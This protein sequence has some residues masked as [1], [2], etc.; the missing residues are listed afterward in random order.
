MLF[1]R[2]MLLV[3]SD[4]RFAQLVQTHIHKSFLLTTPA[5]RFEDLA[6][7]V[8]RD[9]DG[10]LL[11]LASDAQDAER[12]DAS[13]R[14]LR[15]QQLPP[16]LAVLSA[17]Q[18]SASRRLDALAPF[19]DG[20]FVWPGHLR[21]FNSWIRRAVVPGAPFP[22]TLTE[23]LAQR[24]RG[25]LLP[26]TPSLA[27]LADQLEIAATHDVTVLIE[28]ETGTGKSYLAKLIHDFS[29]RAAH[30]FLV[31]AG[32]AH[33]GHLLA[34]EF[35]GH[36]KG[37]FSGADAGKVGK[38]EAAGAGTLLIDEID[39]LTLDQQANLLRVIE[40]G[41]FEPVGSNETQRSD[42]RIIVAT[43]WNLSE[44]VALGTFRN[45]LYYRLN[46]LPFRIP[47]LRDRLQDVSPL[48]RGMVARYNTRFAK[49]IG[50]I[51]P[52]TMRALEVFPWPGNI[53]Q[54]E[55][56]VQQAVLTCTGDELRLQHLPPIVH[57]LRAELT[58][59]LSVTTPGPAGSLA[60]NRETTE[61]V[62]ILRALEKVT[63]S[64]TR[65]A[66][67]LGV[68]RVTLYKKMKK[69]G[70]LGKPSGSVAPPYEQQF[71]RVGGS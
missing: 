52:E 34:S 21:E 54:L 5:V 40:N 30:R 60:H 43:N 56:V 18:F 31:V 11:F 26:L 15:L 55:N 17:E 71:S 1:T 47:P 2:R 12:I 64:R 35:F 46:V 53:R 24:I 32:G 22:D 37:A 19:L 50:G 51:H 29:R 8:R 6:N 66:E 59:S 25:R 62:A 61:R 16:R 4:L 67:L 69:Y 38:F 41:E 7:L 70:L 39:A 45:D 68:S 42:A 33:S 20:S 14:E 13:V 63:F 27:P 58:V 65:A 10:V 23:N 9:T 44:A 36:S 3:G 57:T 49:R 28:G 48:V